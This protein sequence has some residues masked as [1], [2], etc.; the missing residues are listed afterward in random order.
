MII[1]TAK[2]NRGRIFAGLAGVAALACGVVVLASLL[3]RST[4]A[5]AVVSPKGVKTAED[6]ISYL[7][8][9]G[10]QVKEEPLAVEELTIPKELGEEYTQYLELQSSQG[11]DLSAY[12]GKTV[13]RYTYEILNYPTG[14]QG[15]QA[16]LLIYRNRVVGGDVLS[17]A[18]NGFIHSLEM[19][20]G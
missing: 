13:K 9:Y 5:G 11:F 15:V 8:A 3:G 19:P 14:E 17:P 1:W 16:S 2:L 20:T 6:R 7:A 4:S 12:A 18:L 10:W